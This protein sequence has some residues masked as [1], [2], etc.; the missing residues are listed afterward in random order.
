M[1]DGTAFRIIVTQLQILLIF[2]TRPIVQRQAVAILVVYSLAWAAAKALTTWIHPRLVRR[3]SAKLDKRSEGLL[4]RLLPT[5]QYFYFPVLGLIF[6]WLAVQLFNRQQLTTGLIQISA[7][8][9]WIIM[10]YR[11]ALALVHI[12][13]S[14]ENAERYRKRILIPIFILLPITLLLNQIVD[15]KTILS[16]QILSFLGYSITLGRI[17][18]AFLWLYIFY[19]LAWITEEGLRKVIM[20][21]TQ[22]DTGVVNTVTTLSRYVIIGGGI[23]VVFGT[24][25]VNLTSLAL[26]G[27]GLSVGIGFGLQQIIANF[28]SGIVLLFE[29]S[30]RPGDVVEV[31]NQVGTVEKLNIRSTIIRT[32]DNV[33]IIV[34]NET[35]LTSQLTTY[36]K[37]DPLVR[38]SV[39]VG[40]GYDSNPKQVQQI[41]M[42]TAVS[43]PLV[44]PYP[45]PVV[46]FEGFGESSIDFTLT[47][48]INEPARRRA[49]K[50]D[51]YFMVWEALASAHIEIPFPQRDLNLRGGWPEFVQAMAQ[52]TDAP[53]PIADQKS[54]QTK[55]PEK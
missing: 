1:V 28:I 52:G 48:W 51:L 35:F 38:V 12:F 29:Q 47:I 16:I 4:Y 20:P 17:L 41:L 18:L 10:V 43:H 13:V 7:T 53:R 49:V 50:S 6:T 24:L 30:L 15:L 40:V 31:N 8:I 33:E 21:R 46:F 45:P 42:D 26:I 39:P 14:E 25:G 54:A 5:T 32:N 55:P 36:T 2:L 27:T 19:I 9:F 11:L 3:L 22:A 23:M 34:P 37:S 44:H